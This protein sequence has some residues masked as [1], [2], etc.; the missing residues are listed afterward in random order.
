MQLQC[1][2]GPM[3]TT[4]LSDWI[5]LIFGA[6]Q[7]GPEAENCY[8][9]FYYL[10]YPDK[11]DLASIENEETR[12][13]IMTQCSHFGQC[14]LCVFDSLH[15]KKR[16]SRETPCVLR[17]CLLTSSNDSIFTQKSHLWLG[18]HCRLLAVS[19]HDSS[20]LTFKPTSL[21]SVLGR[22]LHDHSDYCFCGESDGS[23]C[24]PIVNISWPC[25]CHAPWSVTIDCNEYMLLECFK[26]GIAIREVIGENPHTVCYHIEYYSSSGQWLEVENCT[27]YWNS[28]YLDEEHTVAAAQ[29]AVT[30]CLFKET[31]SRY[32]RLSIQEIPF[33]SFHLKDYFEL[34]PDYTCGS[35]E[36]DLPSIPVSNHIT[37]EGPIIQFIDVYGCCYYP[38]LPPSP[39]EVWE[40]SLPIHHLRLWFGF[41]YMPH[42]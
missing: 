39:M 19:D 6:K 5:D 25:D 18:S 26:V 10:T 16:P 8:N 17:N 37:I 35:P 9:L 15:P 33:S 40:C 3:V 22:D 41:Y 7:Q 14:P 28:L 42:Y 29:T 34:V 20:L 30:T 36:Y 27:V 32:W 13:G 4:F 31:C 12:L 2:E 1:F 24:A 38:S 11:V 23:V 21:Q